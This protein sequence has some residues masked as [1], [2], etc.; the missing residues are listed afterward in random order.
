[1]VGLL[2]PWFA[3]ERA[4]VAPREPNDVDKHRPPPR[5]VQRSVFRF[6]A[7]PP[8][9]VIEV[10]SSDTLPAAA[11]CVRGGVARER[12]S[13]NTGGRCDEDAWGR[14]RRAASRRTRRGRARR[15]RQVREEGGRPRLL[16][17]RV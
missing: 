9:F 2:L 10:R 15:R 13:G 5:A 17:G 3:L 8:R 7:S 16:R 1:M 4:T 6:T 12:R 11:G 14:R